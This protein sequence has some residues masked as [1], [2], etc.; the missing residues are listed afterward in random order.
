[1]VCNMAKALDTSDLEAPLLAE[2]ARIEKSIAALEVQRTA[3]QGMI[4]RYRQESIPLRDVSRKNSFKRIIT[5]KKI[6]ETITMSPPH[7]RADAIFRAA[8]TV[9]F[10]LKESTFRSYLHRLK[11]R[12][13]IEPSTV[14][15]YW[16]LARMGPAE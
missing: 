6:L 14:R 9:H 10:G 13:L 1:M 12:G 2:L 8:C 5:E 16:K 4:T 7:T 11:E 15:G 3:L